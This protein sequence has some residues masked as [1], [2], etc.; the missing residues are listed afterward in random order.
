MI[1]HEYT[2][3][4]VFDIAGENCPT[5]LNEGL[6]QMMEGAP[7]DQADHLVI[8]YMNLKGKNLPL[9]SLDGSFT[10]MP[11]DSAYTAYMMSLSATNFLITKY[12]MSS[13]TG[14]LADI[15]N[16]KTIDQAINDTLL[17]SFGDFVD[18]WVVYLQ[19]R[20]G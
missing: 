4:V 18:R 3:A 7:T 19:N 10:D 11:A 12:G 6:A 1:L 17:L 8:D 13:V 14:I 16:G 9:E 15:K 2:H 20:Q 5:W